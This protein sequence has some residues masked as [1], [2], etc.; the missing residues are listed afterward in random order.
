MDKGSVGLK[1]ETSTSRRLEYLPWT[2][3]RLFSTAAT[4]CR[5]LEP[6]SRQKCVQDAKLQIVKELDCVEISDHKMN[7][8]YY[9]INGEYF[10]YLK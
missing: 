10:Q 3:A 6:S 4:V 9:T 8:C 7:I 2:L 1:S 5:D